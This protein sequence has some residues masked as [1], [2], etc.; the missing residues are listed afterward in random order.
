MTNHQ[1]IKP[2]KCK[3]CGD[4]GQLWDTYLLMFFRCHHCLEIV[5]NWEKVYGTGSE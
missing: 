5:Q 3:H 1:E 4:T 2:C